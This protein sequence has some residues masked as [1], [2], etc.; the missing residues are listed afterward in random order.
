MHIPLFSAQNIVLDNKSIIFL[1]KI[2]NFD[3][4][5]ER[6]VSCISYFKNVSNIQFL[7]KGQLSM[8]IGM[9]SITAMFIS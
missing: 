7:V 3:F 9:L 5:E 6:I 1:S 8:Q 2:D 4:L